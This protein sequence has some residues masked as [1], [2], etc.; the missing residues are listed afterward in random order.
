MRDMF[1][2][3]DSNE[4]VETDGGGILTA[5]VVTLVVAKKVA[6]VATVAAK[7]GGKAAATWGLNQAYNRILN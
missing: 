4:L 5:I 6:P 7:S 1:L 2:E 3:L